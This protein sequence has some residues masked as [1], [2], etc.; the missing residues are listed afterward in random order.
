MSWLSED[1]QELKALA[2]GVIDKLSGMTDHEF[3]AINK[4]LVPDFMKDMK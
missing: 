2:E 4:T 3:V 1:E